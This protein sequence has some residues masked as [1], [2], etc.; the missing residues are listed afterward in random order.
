[1]DPLTP[2]PIRSAPHHLPLPPQQQQT[3]R[4][5]V[6]PLPSVPTPASVSDSLARLRDL[7]GGVSSGSSCS[8]IPTTVNNTSR[9]SSSFALPPTMPSKP[10]PFP[11]SM[12]SFSGLPPATPSPKEEPSAGT[13]ARGGPSSQ[14][15]V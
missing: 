11:S 5:P 6:R 13:A 7:S 9:V 8:T 2:S 1:M 3:P 10:K 4:Q 14:E 12:Y 15:A